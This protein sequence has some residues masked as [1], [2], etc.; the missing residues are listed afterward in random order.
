MDILKNTFLVALSVIFVLVPTVSCSKDSHQYQVNDIQDVNF[1]RQY[2]REIIDSEWIY[3]MTYF[4]YND[5]S[6]D[7]SVPP[8]TFS[9]INLRHRYPLS[10]NLEFVTDDEINNGEFRKAQIQI[11][12]DGVSDETDH[13]MQKIAEYLGY[14]GNS[15]VYPSIEEILKK[16]RSIL[17]LDVIDE[18]LFFKLL[19]KVMN[20]EPQKIG[21][22]FNYPSYALLNEQQFVD[23]YEF[24]VGFTLSMGNIDV[25]IIDV[26]YRN[27]ESSWGYTQLS[28]LVENGQA[29][30]KQK[31]L[32]NYI[33]KIEE[34]IEKNNDFLFKLSQDLSLDDTGI[35]CNRLFA[36]LSDIDK[37]QI[38]AYISY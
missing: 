10:A 13:D 36:F 23:G 30:D 28:D 1:S 11:F 33:T 32:Y 19:D 7:N 25:I 34:G 18:S 6:V 35:D 12:G 4:Y 15:S 22:Y 9:V 31:S 2:A 29:T 37:N 20:S 24:Q 8:L 26:L 5:G 14:G 17:E 27:D 16:D 3:T 38:E 21:K